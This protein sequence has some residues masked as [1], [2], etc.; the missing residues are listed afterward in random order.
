MIIDQLIEFFVKKVAYKSSC[1]DGT[2]PEFSRK[3]YF[4]RFQDKRWC[5]VVVVS[6]VYR[7]GPDNG[8]RGVSRVML[9]V[10]W[11]ERR[12]IDGDRNASG[13]DTGFFQLEESLI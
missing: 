3:K 9:S 4:V 1:F 11:L 5:E 12:E 8:G 7:N 13:G 6:V 10:L 2:F